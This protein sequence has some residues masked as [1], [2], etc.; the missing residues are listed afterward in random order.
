[1]GV[2]GTSICIASG[3]SYNLLLAGRL[4][5]GFGTTAFE[6]LS[7]AVIGDML[8]LPP[9]DMHNRWDHTN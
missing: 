3:E 1:M 5:Q 9:C 6:S 7:I 4:V 2:I 8:V